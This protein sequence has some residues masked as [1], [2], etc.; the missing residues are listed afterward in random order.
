MVSGQRWS[1]VYRHKTFCYSTERFKG[2]FPLS[3]LNKRIFK[4]LKSTVSQHPMGN[5]KKRGAKEKRRNEERRKKLSNIVN[6]TMFI[7]NPLKVLIF[8]LQKHHQLG[9]QRKDSLEKP[10]RTRTLVQR[11]QADIA[12]PG[13]LLEFLRTNDWYVSPIFLICEKESLFFFQYWMLDI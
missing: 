5:W 2:N 10:L 8:N 1:Q 6:V 3:L 7:Q 13:W 11:K 4:N 12:T 9:F